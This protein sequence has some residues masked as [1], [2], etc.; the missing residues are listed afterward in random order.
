MATKSGPKF[1]EVATHLF[2]KRENG[3][4]SRTKMPGTDTS[5]VEII[6]KF[7]QK[8][9]K[10]AFRPKI[11]SEISRFFRKTWVAVL[12]AVL[13]GARADLKGSVCQC[14]YCNCARGNR[15]KQSLYIVI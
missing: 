14:H 11:A 6:V 4:K 10:M 13:L 1:R 8:A 2:L 7:R 15:S 9:L 5:E 3:Y 12:A